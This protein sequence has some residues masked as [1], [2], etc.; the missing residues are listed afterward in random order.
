MVELLIFIIAATIVGIALRYIAYLKIGALRIN[1]NARDSF[2]RIADEALG[3]DDIT[4]SQLDRLDFMARNL[5][6]KWAQIMVFNVYHKAVPVEND[7]SEEEGSDE[8]DRL[9]D[10]RP[11]W[12]ARLYFFWLLA[13]GSQGLLF[14]LATIDILFTHFDIE[15]RIGL[16]AADRRAERVVY[17]LSH[18]HGH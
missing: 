3:S 15:R 13:V 6:S 4:S 2:F 1:R 14:A 18:A 5:M 7:R 11:A 12:P 8:F 16:E 17:Q 9:T 10:K